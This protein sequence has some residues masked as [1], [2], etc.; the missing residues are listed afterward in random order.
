VFITRE[1]AQVDPANRGP[2]FL[3]STPSLGGR[4][5]LHYELTGP[6]ASGTLAVYTGLAGDQ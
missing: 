6:T 5:I 1:Q 2:V 3:S 4:D